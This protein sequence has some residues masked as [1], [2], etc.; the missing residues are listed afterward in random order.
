MD[1][2]IIDLSQ[3]KWASL[4]LKLSLALYNQGMPREQQVE[5]ETTEISE[6]LDSQLALSKFVERVIRSKGAQVDNMSIIQNLVDNQFSTS[7]LFAKKQLTYF[8]CFFYA[9]YILLLLNLD[10]SVNWV[11]WCSC[12]LT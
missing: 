3:A 1:H 12:L 10:Q 9:P 11:C 5:V 8:V 6:I 2:C 4:M 7:T